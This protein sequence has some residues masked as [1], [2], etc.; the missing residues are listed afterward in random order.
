MGRR[1]REAFEF[2]HP[3][4]RPIDPAKP[5]QMATGRGPQLVGI[6]TDE[7]QPRA[8]PLFELPSR[9]PGPEQLADVAWFHTPAPTVL[10][11][12]LEFE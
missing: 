4:S 10:G 3:K 11:V 1:G 8:A 9:A 12:E 7:A 2:G 5:P 6:L